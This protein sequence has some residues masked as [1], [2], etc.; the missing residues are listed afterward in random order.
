MKG[1]PPIWPPNPTF[2]QVSGLDSSA[3][4]MIETQRLVLRRWQ[5]QD[6]EALADVLADPRVV[7]A[8]RR[9]PYS[10]EKVEETHD[11]ILN[12][13]GRHGYGPWATFEKAS[14]RYVGHIGLEYMEDW[15]FE[16]KTEVGYVLASQ[17]W[18]RGYA[19]EAARAS[20]QHG[21]DVVGLDRIIS[22]TYE[23]HLASRR[24]MEKCGMTFQGVIRWRDADIAWYALDR[25]LTSN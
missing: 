6:L 15:P 18:G 19:T 7:A 9:E 11:Y 12:H 8:L 3:V 23:D 25:P 17:V 14:G 21:F 20:L 4:K 24:V 1:F 5:Q 2:L 10:R 13:W 22:T 16:H